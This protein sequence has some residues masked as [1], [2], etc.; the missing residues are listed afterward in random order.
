MAHVGQLRVRLRILPLLKSDVDITRIRLIDTDLL[1]ETDASG[2]A[3]WQFSHKAGSRT[4]V[5]IRDVAVEQVEIERL[6]VTLRSG[7]TGSP[8]AH[9][10]LDS[11]K[12]TRSAA[13][14]SLA[15]ELKGSSNGQPVALSGQTGPLR[16]LFAGM[17]FPLMLSGDVA[18]ATVKL[19]GGLA[20]ALT[21]EGIDLTVEATGTDL[22]TL[23]K[24]LAVTI[25]QTDKFDVTAQLTGSGDDLALHEA[26]GSASHKGIELSLNGEI[27][28]LKRLEDIQLALKGSGNDLAELSTLVGKTLPQTGPFEVSGKLTGSAKAL[29]LSE[30]QGTIGHASIK[31]ALAGGIGDLIALEGIDLHLKGSGNDLAELS[32]IVAETLPKTGPFEV[33]GK[34]TGTTKGT[35]P[36]RGAGDHRPAEHQGLAGGQDR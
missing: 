27:G 22:A 32:S 9:Y 11:L 26:R 25:P 31:L 6:A 2:Q 24:G 21:L 34:L 1:L 28:D 23:G 16:D 8:A 19:H 4:G 17:R 7:E 15:V 13:A 10:K 14:D 29:V 36:Q 35:G 18:G 5:G 33:S 20:N 30:A 3:N 12:L